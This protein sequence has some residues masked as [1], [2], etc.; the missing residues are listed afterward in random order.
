MGS[1]KL[2]LFSKLDS[3]VTPQN[4]GLNLFYYGLKDEQIQQRR[5]SLLAV[6]KKELQQAAQDLVL[7]QML[8]GKSSQVVFGTLPDGDLGAQGWRVEDFSKGLKLRTKLYQETA[9]DR[10]HVTM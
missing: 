1:A 9:E 5:D 7:S 10:E 8:S 3:P 4:H 2:S 6:T